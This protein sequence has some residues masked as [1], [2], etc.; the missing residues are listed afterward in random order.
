MK[1]KNI[2][3]LLSVCLISGTLAWR[4]NYS[5]DKSK[6]ALALNCGSDKSFKSSDGFIYEADQ[7]FREGVVATYQNHPKVP[8]AGFKYTRDHKLHRTERYNDKG[9][10]EYDLPVIEDGQYVLIL[11][12]AEVTINLK[13]RVILELGQL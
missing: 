13:L 9:P 5:L 4:P 3:S 8:R 2:F 11:Q 1:Q 10:L 12:F 7:Y 6:V